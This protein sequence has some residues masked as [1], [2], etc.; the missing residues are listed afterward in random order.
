MTYAG[1]HI[2]LLSFEGK[3]KTAQL[4]FAPGLTLIYGASNTGKSLAVKA[5]DFMLGSSQELPN[6]IE[7][8]P[9]AQFIIFE[10]VDPPLKISDYASV[11]TFTNDLSNGR[12]GLL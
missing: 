4:I 9:N 1:W 12:Q 3:D 10:N 5:F 11:E 8:R 6:I 7:R 2:D